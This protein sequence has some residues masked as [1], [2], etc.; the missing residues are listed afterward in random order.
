M[1]NILTTVFT[2]SV[3]CCFAA[4]LIMEYRAVLSEYSA[5]RVV[6]RGWSQATLDGCVLALFGQWARPESAARR[7]AME[8]TLKIIPSL[9][10][11]QSARAHSVDSPASVDPTGIRMRD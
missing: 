8:L 9:S 10:R 5:E 1:Y 6:P 2:V 3:V 11:L 4:R 7:L